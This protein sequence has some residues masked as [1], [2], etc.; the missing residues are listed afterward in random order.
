MSCSICLD[1]FI[2][3]SFGFLGSDVYMYMNMKDDKLPFYHMSISNN[4][5]LQDA[6]FVDYQVSVFP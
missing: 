1:N 2:F 6:K 4:Q 5:L 3:R